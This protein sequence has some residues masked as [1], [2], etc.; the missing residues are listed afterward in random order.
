M[1]RRQKRF[2]PCHFV[3]VDGRLCG[4]PALR[5][6]TYCFFHM[7]QWRRHDRMVTARIMAEFR[8]QD[9]HQRR[10]IFEKLVKWPWIRNIVLN[11]FSENILR[12]IFCVSDAAALLSTV[13]GEG[14]ERRFSAASAPANNSRDGE[15]WPR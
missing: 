4:S 1:P 8:E 13:M 3:K 12:D 9:R 15:S 6:R 5:R 11:Y 14:V 2:R 7:E 10:L